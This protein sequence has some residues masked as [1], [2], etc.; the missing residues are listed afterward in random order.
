MTASQTPSRSPSTCKTSPTASR[1]DA[2]ASVILAGLPGAGKSTLAVIAS[3]ALKRKIVDTETVFRNET[4]L[5]SPFY[6]KLYGPA[7]YHDR[8]VLVLQHILKSHSRNTIVVSSWVEKAVQSQLKQLMNTNPVIHVARELQAIQEYLKVPHNAKLCGLLQAGVAGFRQCTQFEFFNVSENLSHTHALCLTDPTSPAPYLTLKRAERHFLKFL[9]LILPADSIPFIETAFPLASIPTEERKFTYAI[10]MPLSTLLAR[11]LD[12]EE[13]ETGADAIEIVVDDLVHLPVVQLSTSRER[14]LDSQRAS[15]ISRCF[16]H[17]RRNT[18]IPIMYHVVLPK[19]YQSGQSIASEYLE[20]LHQ[21]LRLAPEYISVDLKLDDEAIMDIV[22][23][24]GK[25]KLIGHLHWPAPNPPPW[26]DAL[27]RSYYR[28]AQRLGCDL[29][30]LTRANLHFDENFQA[31]EIQATVRALGEPRLPLI[32]YNTGQRGKSSACFN[33]TLTSVKPVVA[34]ED[35]L[36]DEISQHFP[37]PSISAREATQ[38]LH[39]SFV[40]SSMKLFVVG[41]NVSYSLS[42]AMHNAALAALGIPHQYEPHSTPSIS[43]LRDLAYHPLFAGASVG[44][45]FKVEV[46]KHTHALSRHAKAI[47]AVNT[48][49]PVRDLKEDGSIPEGSSFFRSRNTAGPVKAL[50]G[51]NTDWIGIRACIRRGLSPANAVRSSSCG[52]VIGAGGMAR[53]A[54]YSLLQLGVKNVAIFNRT[55]AHA[56]SL[57]AHF[58]T[59]LSRDDF[60]LLSRDSSVPTRFYIVKSRDEP[61]PKDLRYPSMI[62][63]CIPTHSISDSPAPNFAVPSQ[64][65]SSPTGGVVIELGY[66]TLNTPLLKQSRREAHR[67]WVT[68]DGLDLLPEQGFAQF[69]LFTGR[70]APRRLMR[71]EVL[72]AY[73]CEHE[74]PDIAHQPQPSLGRVAAEEP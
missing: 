22:R 62:V 74:Q 41:A 28:K 26:T 69:E 31:F 33:Q 4:G 32:A 20:Y 50:Y 67:G 6:R 61:W 59:L 24:K 42:P 16:G 57:V 9:S 71:R 2:N 47:G 38:A 46:I 17:I 66:K 21:G 39:A 70:R 10:S 45:P 43:V 51:E 73:A 40:F 13:M 14:H 48:I 12:I 53:A 44:L 29:V 34:S 52:L 36:N 8:Q 5:S 7:A 63:S 54:V 58:T 11:E 56:E 37:Q 15:Q 60:P 1:F 18:V 49:I 35:S 23:H 27:W 25:S 68:M 30:R 19:T 72:R 65:L 55:Y 64:W 3:S